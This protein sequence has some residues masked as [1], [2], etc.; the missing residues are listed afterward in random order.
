MFTKKM[1][2]F[3]KKNWPILVICLL[4]IFISYLSISYLKLS[5]LSTKLIQCEPKPYDS[6]WISARFMDLNDCKK[7]VESFDKYYT[8]TCAKYVE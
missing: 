3:I 4:A 1:K 8:Y 5:A 6:C 7:A 2:A